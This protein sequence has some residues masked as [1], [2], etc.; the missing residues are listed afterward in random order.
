MFRMGTLLPSACAIA[1]VIALGG[2]ALSQEGKNDEV[3]TKTRSVTITGPKSGNPL[4]AFDISWFDSGLNRYYLAD[5]SNSAV[6]VITPPSAV[7]QFQPGFVGVRFTDTNGNL[8]SPPSATCTVSNDVSG[9]DGV[10]TLNNNGTKQLWVGDGDSRVWV[11]NPTTGAVL[12]APTG[13][14]NPI[15]TSKLFLNLR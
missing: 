8:C 2:T 6:D 15:P 3:F 11:L 10:L 4:I 1:A 7:D 14:T 9:P 12:P 13:A 5:R